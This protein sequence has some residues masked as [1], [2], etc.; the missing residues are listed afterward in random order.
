MRPARAVFQAKRHLTFVGLLAPLRP[1]SSTSYPG[2][3]R[4]HRARPERPPR[5]VC[6]QRGGLGLSVTIPDRQSPSGTDDFGLSRG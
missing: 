2:S 4:P 5:R 3:G 6:D 1:S